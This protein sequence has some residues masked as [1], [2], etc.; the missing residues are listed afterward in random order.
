MRYDKKQ[1][2]ITFHTPASCDI[3]D[4]SIP[5]SIAS[6]R[7]VTGSLPSSGIPQCM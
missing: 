7:E 5:Y 3:A 1:K 2:Y 4:A 6:W